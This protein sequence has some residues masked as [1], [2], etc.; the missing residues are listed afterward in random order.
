M[1]QT[2]GLVVLQ[3]CGFFKKSIERFRHGH[4]PVVSVNLNGIETRRALNQ[5][6]PYCTESLSRAFTVIIAT[7]VICQHT[8]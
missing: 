5:L 8:L 3:L 2:G 7:L 1:T 6:Y 4:V